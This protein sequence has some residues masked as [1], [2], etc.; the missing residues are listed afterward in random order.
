MGSGWR[1]VGDLDPVGNRSSPSRWRGHDGGR[2][3]LDVRMLLLVE[4]DGDGDGSGSYPGHRSPPPG[5]RAHAG[6]GN[7]STILLCMDRAR[8]EG[9]ERFDGGAGD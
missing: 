4:E 3:R 5:P 8:V 9:H 2:G 6:H 7:G 1:G